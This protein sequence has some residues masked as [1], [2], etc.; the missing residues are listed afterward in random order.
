MVDDKKTGGGGG[1]MS[2][3]ETAGKIAVLLGGLFLLTAL[4]V[5][6]LAYLEG[7]GVSVSSTGSF[8]T[9]IVEYFLENIWPVWVFIAAIITVLAIA[10][11][12]H[13]LRKIHEIS[14]EEKA[15]YN[16]RPQRKGVV[17]GVGDTSQARASESNKRWD[18]L[19]ENLNSNSAS[20]WRLAIIE[21]DVMLDELLR[22]LGLHGDS[23]GEMLKSADKNEFATIDEAWDAH[24]VRND[25]AHS[26]SDFQLNEREAKRVI[27]MF[28]KVFKEFNLI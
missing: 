26:G 18:K 3:S 8:W 14:V 10:G 16:P 1:G 2:D 25:I 22:K 19:I 7:L 6:L 28:E 23:I 15:I 27:A 21:A 13:N 24:K 9:S 20:D 11:I 12:I 17:I 5:A 4:S